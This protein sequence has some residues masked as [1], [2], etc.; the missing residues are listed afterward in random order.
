MIKLLNDIDP[1]VLDVAVCSIIVLIIFFGA[2]RGLKKTAINFF[3]L[4]ISVFLGFSS[5]VSS[6]K[7]VI[8]GKLFLVENILPAGT[9]SFEV[10]F[11]YLLGSIFSSLVFF[12]LIYIVLKV[13]LILFD[14][15]LKKRTGGSL[16]KK[17]IVGRVFGGIISFVYG[18]VIL[19]SFL[20]VLNSNTLGM[21]ETIRKSTVTKFLVDNTSDL[22]NKIEPDLDKKIVLKIY[23]GDLVAEI[24]DDLIKSYTYIDNNIISRV[25]GEGYI[26]NVENVAF[27]KEETEEIMKNYALDLSNISI[28]SSNLDD[29][30]KIIKDKYIKMS[31]ELIAVMNKTVHN[32]SLGD[33]GFSIEEKGLMRSAIKEAGVDESGVALFNE[34]LEGVTN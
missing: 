13:A 3:V 10:F 34:I 5:Y 7:D 18:G 26:S 11:C 23:K 31:G 16:K 24:S 32:N 9:G 22:L 4:A 12:L 6:V 17:T 20:F 25:E 33:L 30:N 8:I 19:I 27:T 14:M 29:T 1:L 28:L 21:G 2:L 15:Y